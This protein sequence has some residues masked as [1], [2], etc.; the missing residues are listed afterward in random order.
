MTRRCLAVLLLTIGAAT[1]PVV[2]ADD[3][4]DAEEVVAKAREAHAEDMAKV[5]GEVAKQIEDK[6][7]AVKKRKKPEVK[8]IEA[9]RAEREAL[10]EGKLPKWIRKSEQKQITEANKRLMTALDELRVVYVRVEELE[11]AKA[12]EE[13]IKE[14]RKD[15]AG[16]AKNQKVD[17]RKMM[18]GAWRIDSTVDDGV[19]KPRE[20]TWV[21]TLRGDEF[22]AEEDGVV[23]FEG[24]WG[25][26][27][28][29]C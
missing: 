1:T 15:R 18:Q 13:E 4:T 16:G 3:V 27:A 11:K 25:V 26:D 5:R 22:T 12:V 20:S 29:A 19:L 8:D 23:K 7:E 9:L 28:R 17:L 21:I 24:T 14:L 10:E 2:N 6:I